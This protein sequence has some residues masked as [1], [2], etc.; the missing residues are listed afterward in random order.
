VTAG[1]AALLVLSATGLL[2]LYAIAR[3]AVA[4]RPVLSPH[5]RPFRGAPP[6]LLLASAAGLFL[7]YGTGMLLV[8]SAR[9]GLLGDALGVAV[10]LGASAVAVWFVLKA[11]LHPRGSLRWRVGMALLHL[12]AAYP[13]IVL[14]FLLGE[15][16]GLPPKQ[17]AVEAIER[18]ADGWQALV[19]FALLVAPIA[20]E[21]CFRG[22]LYP[23]LRHRL[24]RVVAILLTS[25]AFA[26]IHQPPTTWV[27]IAILGAVLAYLVEGTGSILPAIAAHA[28]FNAI[29]VAELLLF[30]T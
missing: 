6:G 26:L 29:T 14:T 13:L 27:P 8:G 20:E 5:A 10:G 17:A 2:A 30:P 19:L 18:R 1:N 16:L 25:V 12:W 21:I 24:G 28:V 7:L 15:A 11:V 23:A 22:L 4:G 3:R 9:L